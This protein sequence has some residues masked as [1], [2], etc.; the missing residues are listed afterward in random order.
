MLGR[1]GL[2]WAGLGSNISPKLIKLASEK[3]F[4]FLGDMSLI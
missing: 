3:I 2:C 1:V 4:D